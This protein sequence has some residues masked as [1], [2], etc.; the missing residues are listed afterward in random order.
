MLLHVAVIRTVVVLS[1][2]ARRNIPEDGILQSHRREILKS[3]K[4][5]RW[6]R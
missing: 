3:Y 1:R 6:L 5:L 2:A 4:T